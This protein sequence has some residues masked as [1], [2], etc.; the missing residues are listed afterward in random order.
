MDIE[1]YFECECGGKATRRVLDLTSDG[2]SFN[3]SCLGQ[4]IF[5]CE[6]CGKQYFCGDWEEFCISEDYL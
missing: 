2:H 5:E 3:V 4:A 1:L 6:E